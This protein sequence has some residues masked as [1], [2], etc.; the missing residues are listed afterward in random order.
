MYDALALL[1][2]GTAR[3]KLLR[4]FSFNPD[5]E[6]TVDEIARRARLVRRTARTELSVLERAGVIKK[7]TI[8]IAQEGKKAKVKEQVFFCDKDFP[9]LLPMHRFLTD[10]APIGGE[11]V[12]SHLKKAGKFDVVVTAG[13]FIR[14]P[15]QVVDVLLAAKNPDLA[16]VENAIRSIEADIGKSIRFMLLETEDLQY[17]L[18]MYD[19]HTRDIFDYPHTVLTDKI[20]LTNELSKPW[21]M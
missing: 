11:T 10:T 16:K 12:L 4:F 18:G 8:Q 1:F 19:K 6:Y 13:I 7:K 17:R 2:D 5:E 15:D 3:M 21:I 14:E 20:G 9:F